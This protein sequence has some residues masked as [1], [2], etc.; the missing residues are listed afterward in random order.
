MQLLELAVLG[1][2]DGEKTLRMTSRLQHERSL[3]AKAR[4]RHHADDHSDPTVRL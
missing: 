1:R 3:L 4:D 2:L